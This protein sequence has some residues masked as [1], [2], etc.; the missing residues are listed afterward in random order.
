M[1]TP[2][3]IWQPVAADSSARRESHNLVSCLRRGP[4]NTI[5]WAMDRNGFDDA[6]KPVCQTKSSALL[7]NVKESKIG[8]ESMGLDLRRYL[9]FGGG[10]DSSKYSR[11]EQQ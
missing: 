7:L 8:T 10:E 4:R 9:R 11:F 3:L 2:G 1:K 5:A 6:F